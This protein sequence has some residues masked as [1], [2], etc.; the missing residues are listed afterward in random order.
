[1]NITVNFTEKE[2]SELRVSLV[3]HTIHHLGQPPSLYEKAC[4][5]ILKAAEH[6]KQKRRTGK[7]VKP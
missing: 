1:M 2:L 3:T 7:K 6:G 4:L 5:R